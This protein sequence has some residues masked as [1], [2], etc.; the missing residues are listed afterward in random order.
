MIFG[1]YQLI[2]GFIAMLFFPMLM[3]FD[4]WVRITAI[5]KFS[6]DLTLILLN[7]HTQ[8]KWIH[9]C[10][11][12]LSLLS[13]DIWMFVQLQFLSFWLQEQLFDSLCYCIG[14]DEANISFGPV[15][16]MPLK[17]AFF[18]STLLLFIRVVSYDYFIFCSSWIM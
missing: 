12:W 15:E 18:F 7:N 17:S 16:G 10:F 3:I 14:I 5:W 6:R 9:G 2:L 11:L 8:P 13:H 1:P 4:I